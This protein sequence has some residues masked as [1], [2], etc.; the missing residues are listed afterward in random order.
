MPADAGCR[1]SLQNSLNAAWRIRR[2]RLTRPACALVVLDQ[3]LYVEDPAVLVHPDEGN[4]QTD[5]TR[6][7]LVS[8]G[9]GGVAGGSDRATAGADFAGRSL[10]FELRGDALR[11]L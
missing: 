7:G 1:Y 11:L 3:L 4:T 10:P 9:K 2:A 8:A 5:R 6:L